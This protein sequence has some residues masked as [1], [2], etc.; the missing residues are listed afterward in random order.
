MRK[1][2]VIYKDFSILKEP[3]MFEAG[4]TFC[5]AKRRPSS[6]RLPFFDEQKT[7]P[8]IIEARGNIF[9]ANITRLRVKEKYE[10]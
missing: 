9:S 3:R 2:T 6:A 8:A 7:D 4:S 5:E 1:K 10:D